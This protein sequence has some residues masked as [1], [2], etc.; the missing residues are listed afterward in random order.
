MQENTSQLMLVSIPDMDREGM[1]WIELHNRRGLNA[2]YPLSILI[3]MAK[4]TIPVARF[5]SE[6]K[7]SVKCNKV[8][9]FRETIANPTRITCQA[10]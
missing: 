4:I 3:E 1:N 5:N 7:N 8:S 6:E 10:G 9:L 2:R